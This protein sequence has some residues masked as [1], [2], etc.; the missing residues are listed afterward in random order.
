MQQKSDEQAAADNGGITPEM[1][2]TDGIAEQADSAR[3]DW[4]R[5][6]KY[7][8]FI[9]WGLYSALGGRWNG[10]TYYG[11][12]E[13]IQRRAGIPAAD[14]ARTA[15]TF[16][17]T[18]F[19]A[20]AWV[21]L[22]QDAG[23]RYI[24][25][26]AKHHD[27][28]AMF[29]TASSPFNI[30]D[31]TPFRRD[32]LAELAIAC[33]EA[34][35]RL[36]FYY[37]QT[38][39]WHELDAPVNNSDATPDADFHRYLHGKALPQIEEL[40]TQYGDVALIWFDTPGPITREES[41]ALMKTIRHL[42]PGCLINSRIGNGIGDYES[43][44]DQEIPS[45]MHDGLWETVDTHNDTWGFV[46]ADQNWKS[47][48][49]LIERLVVVVSRGGN[50]MLN[51]GPDGLG[52]VPALSARIIRE[53]GRWLAAHGEAIYDTIPSPLG[54][55]PW[56]ECTQ[57]GNTLYLHVFQWP[58]D[59]QLRLPGVQAGVLGATLLGAN[60]PLT[61]HSDA[62]GLVLHL[63]AVPPSTLLPVIAV[64]VERSLPPTTERY[65]LHN[66][67]N[68]LTA[69]AARCRGCSQDKLSWMEKFGDW[70]HAEYVGQ[71][72]GT[73]SSAA[74]T[75][76]A[77]E[78]GMYYI[79][80]EYACPTAADDSTWSL[81]LGDS[82]LTFPLLATGHFPQRRENQHAWPLA[83]FRTYRIG[84]YDIPAAGQY[85]LT[86]RPLDNDGGAMQLV[87]ITLYP[88]AG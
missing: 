5:K 88:T 61:V 79:D 34:G 42:Q 76:S 85:T 44:G 36:G 73:G 13:W 71:W 35:L 63:P 87:T 62:G 66:C 31:A 4:F 20:R 21:K 50:Y 74:W 37:S 19:D 14:Y 46:H 3:G 59:G 49:E 84:L 82:E 38:Q 25:I 68:V 60:E 39:D 32:P 26:T 22:A 56:G 54:A 78:P 12:G 29:R 27:G 48:R 64:E 1:W 72:Q 30:V 41:L 58:A 53:A 45:R 10:R 7:A 69:S 77:V 83:R 70:K 47:A 55:L 51:I 9:H 67:V 15:A 23:M 52:R 40:L 81:T 80:V 33:R 8:M 18:G 75:F 17:P 16:N 57:R 6:A 43:L 2:G 28:F 86:L 11:I 24:V 65:V